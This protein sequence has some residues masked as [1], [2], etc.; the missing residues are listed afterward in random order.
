MNWVHTSLNVNS[1]TVQ[2]NVSTSALHLHWSVGL[3]EVT[4]ITRCVM[5]KCCTLLSFKAPVHKLQSPLAATICTEMCGI[6]LT[7]FHSFLTT[8]SSPTCQGFLSQKSKKCEHCYQFDRRRSDCG[9]KGKQ[10]TLLMKKK[11]CFRMKYVN[12]LKKVTFIF[13]TRARRRWIKAFHVL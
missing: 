9:I 5:W 3:I 1:C 13:N 8:Y 4:V 2:I 6:L 11:E 12:L 7:Q 10:Y